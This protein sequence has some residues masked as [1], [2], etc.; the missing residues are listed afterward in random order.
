MVHSALGLSLRTGGPT[1][2]LLATVAIGLAYA[3]DSIF[4]IFRQYD[5]EGF[6]LI[7]LKSFFQG[8]ALY[9]EVYSCYQPGFYELNWV[10]FKLW[11]AP[12]C[13]DTMRCRSFGNE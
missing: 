10:V 7:S 8:G 11:G 5:D 9:D 2:L 3:Y 1:L 4:S 12:L 6:I 13:H